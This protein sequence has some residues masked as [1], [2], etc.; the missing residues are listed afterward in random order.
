MQNFTRVKN[1]S[2][3]TARPDECAEA[4]VLISKRW[5]FLFPSRVSKTMSL[6]VFI[7]TVL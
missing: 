5:D 6:L 3:Q 1:T 4:G 2:T 7:I